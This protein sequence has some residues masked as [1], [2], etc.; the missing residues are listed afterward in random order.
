MFTKL[1]QI[2]MKRK[3]VSALIALA[4]FGGG[5]SIWKKNHPT[6]VAT[7][8]VIG[9]VEQGTLTT[10]VTG[11]GQVSSQNEL[12]LKPKVSGDIT[13]IAVKNGATVKAGSVIAVLDAR[14]AYKAVR[15]AQSSLDS[16]NIS[17]QKLQQPSTAYQIEQA[18]NSLNS[19]QTILD[20]LILSQ[21]VA[22]TQAVIAKQK[23]DD[24]LVSAYDDAFNDIASA[25]L[26]LPDS[27]SS[28]YNNLYSTEISDAQI[29]IGNSQSNVLSLKIST[30][31]D[32]KDALTPFESSA[33]ADY[34]SA[35]GVYDSNFLSYKNSHRSDTHEMIESLLAQTLNTTRAM[36][37]A[38]KSQSNYMDA[39]VDFRTRRGLVIFPTV[40]GYQAD[41]SS[42]I[43]KVNGHVSSLLA[44]QRTLNNAKQAVTDAATDLTTLEHNQPLDLAASEGT[45]RERQLSLDTLKA[46]PDTLDIASQQLSVTQ[47]RNALYD[48]QLT[49]ANYTIRAPF[50][51]LVTGITLKKG[52]TVSASTVITTLLGHGQAA[53]LSLN[54]VDAAKVAVGQ[55]VSLTFDAVPDVTLTG[56]VSD[57]DGVGTV[58]QGVVTYVAT[59][60]FDTADDHIK[61]GMTVSAT[62]ITNVK[63]DAL[64][65]PSSAV[66]TQGDVSYVEVFDVPMTV[67]GTEGVTSDTAPRH[68]VVTVGL[69]NDTSTEIISGLKAGD[70]IVTRTVTAAKTATQTAPSLFGGAGTRGATTGA[71]RAVAR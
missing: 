29:S 66:K 25:F 19:A 30:Y 40:S 1:W 42:I 63:T 60:V 71:T 37:Q 17:L 28:L 54:E 44:M 57:L 24:A 65:V 4:L 15:D 49:L 48:A 70:Q 26:D 6:V 12:A 13:Q 14:D 67:G 32:Y 27:V 2:I 34:L 43:G 22:H 33:V 59:I 31:Q 41:L 45:L 8:Y 61:P 18:Q 11:S 68:Q 21:P 46:G 20:K 50:D 3:V 64:M 55:K 56:V 35:R 38:A 69:E 36:A 7:R 9:T 39:W 10:A 16:A 58:S 23:A 53:T 62:I 51:G 52:D 47:R 5:Y